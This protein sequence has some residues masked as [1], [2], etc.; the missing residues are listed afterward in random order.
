MVVFS[1]FPQRLFIYDPD[2]ANTAENRYYKMVAGHWLPLIVY[3]PDAPDADCGS[4][5]CTG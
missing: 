1:H 4:E 5:D 2:S 3:L